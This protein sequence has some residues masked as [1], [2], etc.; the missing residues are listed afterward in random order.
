MKRVLAAV[1]LGI[2]IVG[3][4]VM[5][6]LVI[7]QWPLPL[8][9]PLAPFMAIAV[10]LTLVVCIASVFYTLWWAILTLFNR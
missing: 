10:F 3:I 4:A 9:S 7:T 6:A 8:G 5:D 2:W 1:V